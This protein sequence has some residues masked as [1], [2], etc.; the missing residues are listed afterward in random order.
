M[1]TVSW[2][3]QN[4]EGF[5]SEDWNKV[6]QEEDKWQAPENLMQMVF[7]ER[8]VEINPAEAELSQVSVLNI[9]GAE[10]AYLGSRYEKPRC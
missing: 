8:S 9:K 4:P 3:V 10:V 7:R 1:P 2:R 6:Q 5:Y